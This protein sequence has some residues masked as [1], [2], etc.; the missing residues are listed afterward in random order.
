MMP[1]NHGL[2]KCLSCRKQHHYPLNRLAKS[3]PKLKLALVWY[4]AL[5]LPASAQTDFELT[6]HVA[7]LIT[8]KKYKEGL[9]LSEELLEKNPGDVATRYN[10]AVICFH[11]E[12][13][14][15][16]L[17]DFKF[18]SDLDPRNDSFLFQTANLYESV[19]SLVMAEKYY[20]R[21]LRQVN[22]NFMYF[23]K[24]G[25][26]YLK[27]GWYDKAI[28]DFNQS[29]RLNEEHHNSLHNRGI[30]WYK[31]GERQKACEDWCQA[32]L[33]G[34]PVSARHLDRNCRTYPEPCLLSR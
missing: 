18:L 17:A 1:E 22:R 19:D 34:N 8:Q 4:V 6:D 30:A 3:D 5:I 20:T 7:E 23:F 13:F 2:E 24:R 21:A 9:P 15:E 28:D 29:L 33:K 11:L 25:T 12:M 14:H 16:A 10:H 32:L 31:V 27:L 26:C